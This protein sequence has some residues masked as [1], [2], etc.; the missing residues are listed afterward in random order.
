MYSF[1]FC[2]VFSVL[3]DFRL[4]C[5]TIVTPFIRRLTRNVSLGRLWPVKHVRIEQL[6]PFTIARCIEDITLPTLMNAV[7]HLLGATQCC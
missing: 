2:R 1:V 3:V 5:V 6:Q 7:S 4:H